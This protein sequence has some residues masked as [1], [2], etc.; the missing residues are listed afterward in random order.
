VNDNLAR[1][2]SCKTVA[3][4]LGG[5]RKRS[6]LAQRGRTTATMAICFFLAHFPRFLAMVDESLKTERDFLESLLQEA[7]WAGLMSIPQEPQ[8]QFPNVIQNALVP[9]AE[10]MVG[11]VGDMSL[12]PLQL[13][14]DAAHNVAIESWQTGSFVETWFCAG[15]PFC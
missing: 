8:M 6:V 11:S 9:L 4:S 14:R 12:S 15:L 3:E 13:W 5:S 1:S 7:P 2:E 10:G